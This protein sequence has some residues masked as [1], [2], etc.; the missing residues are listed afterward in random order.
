[1]ENKNIEEKEKAPFTIPVD[2]KR[3][4]CSTCKGVGKVKNIKCPDCGG[5]GNSD[6]INLLINTLEAEKGVPQKRYEVVITDLDT[7]KILY[8][9]KS[10]G[11]VVS[12]VEKVDKFSASE[13]E[14][15]FQVAMWGHPLIQRFGIDR[16][17]ENFAKNIEQYLDALEVAGMFFTDREQMR[18]AMI[19]G[20]YLKLQQIMNSVANKTKDKEIY[21]GGN[22]IREEVAPNEKTNK[23]LVE[24]VRRLIA[25]NNSYAII[26]IEN[27]NNAD[28]T[29]DFQQKV[30]VMTKDLGI[31]K[32]LVAV[33]E[34]AVSAKAYNNGKNALNNLEKAAMMMSL[35]KDLA[36][37]I[38]EAYDREKSK[39]EN[40]PNNN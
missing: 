7:K 40:S 34:S 17:E 10:F 23:D 30:E 37:S 6:R 24:E 18:E 19:K 11:G 9:D 31:K 32:I 14:G 36:Q 16:L 22:V 28:I 21:K 1:M 3:I 38:T 29:N 25:E 26:T 33:L 8:K 27:N 39:E 20:N 2:T 35:L 13:V 4:T 5:S 12:M 15:N